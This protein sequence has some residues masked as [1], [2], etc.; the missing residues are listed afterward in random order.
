MLARTALCLIAALIACAPADAQP[1]TD[2]DRTALASTIEDTI[3]GDTYAGA[4]WGI[5]VVNLRSGTVL[6]S[7]RAEDL[8]VPA[9]N[10]KLLTTAAALEQLGPDFRYRTRVYVDGRVED[11]T[12]YGNLIVRGSGDPSLGHVADD[13]DSPDPTAVFR[14]WADSL[15]ARGITHVTGAIVGDDT[16][17]SD[18]PL[19]HGWSWDDAPYGYSAEIGGLA[20]HGN[21]IHLRVQGQQPGQPARLEWRPMNTDYVSVVNRTRTVRDHREADEEYERMRGSNTIHV[22]T[23]LPPGAVEEEALTVTNPTRYTA[24][25]LRETLLRNGVSVQGRAVDLDDS[26]FRPAYASDSVRV[27]ATHASPPLRDL[28]TTLNRESDNLYAEQILRTLSVATPPDTT[29]PDDLERGSSAMGARR[30]GATLS[31]AGV[32]TSQ[33]RIADGS[34]LSRYNLVSP[35]ML[36]GLLQYM[37][38]HED[39]DVS[40]AFHDS[41]PVG[42]RD[43]TLEYRFR[44][45]APAN[46]DVH[47][48]TGTL[49]GVSAL[50]GY[51]SSARGT[52]L[53]FS[54]VCNHHVAESSAVRTAQ[55][56]IVN[57]LARL[58]Q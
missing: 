40:A 21:T 18:T 5:Q 15:R 17:F 30:V 28:V 51:V 14:A 56:V 49:S 35:S 50:T 36:T 19:G 39:A 23:R 6:Y 48:K 54:I 57:T 29:D 37:W 34:G 26:P 20:F 46:G 27:V 2:V 53:A 25:V 12:L 44:G 58:A 52:P 32:D 45:G 11:G 42:G 13:A 31:H 9:S 41:L 24:H 47:A 4:S 38:T 1:A 33:V 55:D 43:G 3:R 7:H 22:D 10:V 8:F 16:I